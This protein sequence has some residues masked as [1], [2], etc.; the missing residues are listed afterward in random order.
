MADSANL[1][2]GQVVEELLRCLSG[3]PR[4]MNRAIAEAEA[5]AMPRI[6]RFERAL[7]EAHDE[8]R[9]AEHAL[10][11]SDD[12]EARW[13]EDRLE[14]A[15]A[16]LSYMESAGD[17]LLAAL[18]HYR[19][20]A[21]ELSRLD[22]EIL[23]PAQGFLDG[24][25]QALAEYAGATP[26]A[27]TR[28]VSGTQ[29]ASA[30]R[31]RAAAPA[32]VAALASS[33]PLLPE[34]YAWIQIEK[35]PASQRAD[36][37]RGMPRAAVEQG[38]A[39]FAADFLPRLRGGFP[40]REDLVEF[41]RANGRDNG[42]LVHPESLENVREMFFGANPVAVSPLPRGTYDIEKGHRRIEVAREL[43]WTHIPARLLSRSR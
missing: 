33:L 1:G 7:E 8:V 19:S 2:D 37:S 17:D 43:G 36:W 29:A 32:I 39:T 25:L 4:T 12:D 15:R 3:L 5:E 31:A 41:D 18:G 20:A 16:R 10:E 6:A 22:R 9:N 24:R 27:A 40:A 13:Q 23:A 30:P 28:A 38:L 42:G 14:E 21:A 35:L 34:G 26:G 11:D